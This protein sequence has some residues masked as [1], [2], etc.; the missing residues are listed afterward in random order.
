MIKA[1]VEDDRVEVRA[2]GTVVQIATDVSNLINGLHGNYCRAGHS[3]VAE[4]FRMLMTAVITRPESPVWEDCGG[5]GVMA[6]IPLDVVQGKEDDDGE[7]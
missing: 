3:G 7:S 1:T 5:E 4:L 6:C 2:S